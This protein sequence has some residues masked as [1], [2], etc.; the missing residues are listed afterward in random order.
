MTEWIVT[1]IALLGAAGSVVGFSMKI[2]SIKT[3]N[4]LDHKA[5]KIVIGEIKQILGTGAFHGIKQ[6]IQDMKENC[7]GEMATV[8]ANMHSQQHEIDELKGK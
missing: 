3:E 2:Q 4:E 6:A 8:K 5:I 7:A 1:I